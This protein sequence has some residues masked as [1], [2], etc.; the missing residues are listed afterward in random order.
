MGTF[1]FGGG[2]P[3]DTLEGKTNV[4][5]VQVGLEVSDDDLGFEFGV[6]TS[7]CVYSTLP[8]LLPIRSLLALSDFCQLP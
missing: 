6:D 4:K 7:V 1:D 2:E 3:M 5:C 8:F